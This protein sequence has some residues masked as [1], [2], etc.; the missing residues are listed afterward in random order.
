MSSIVNG[1]GIKY[2]HANSILIDSEATGENSIAIG[3]NASAT[4]RNAVAIGTNAV[5]NQANTV[6]FGNDQGDKL[7]LT[8]IANG[9]ANDDVAT[10][11]QLKDT[12]LYDNGTAKTAVTFDSNADG[13]TDYSN[14][15]LGG[16]AGT[17]IHNVSTSVAPTDLINVAQL[18][19]LAAQVQNV[20][21]ED[22]PLFNADG[23]RTTEAATASGTHAVAAGANAQ[24]TGVNAVA[25]GASAVANGANAVAIGANSHA[26]GDDSVALG[27]GAVT[28]GPNTV[29][30]GAE[31]S[32]R[33]ITNVAAGTQDTDVANVGQLNQAV[34]DAKNY[35]D[36]MVGGMQG[37][38]ADIGRSAY[39]GIAASTALA[40]IPNIDQDK[41]MSVGVGGA[42]YQGYAAAAVALNLRVTQNLVLKAGAGTTRAGT[43]YGANAS[44]RW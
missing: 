3:G 17:V 44:Y 25:M 38:I 6:S 23:N 29:S 27:A 11:G 19:A 24:A 14:I 9:V 43:V 10:I 1:K 16:T 42:S 22:N 40:M 8:H 30:V 4:A 5:A 36:S 21:T 41:T 20:T 26:S 35:T 28:D 2:F 37:A 15:T 18:N 13:T 31:G 12:G 33:Q 7:R 32:E 34:A 39:S